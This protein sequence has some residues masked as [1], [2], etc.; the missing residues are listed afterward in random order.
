MLLLH[1]G[2]GRTR[3]SCV[4]MAKTSTKKTS[5]SAAIST[6]SFLPCS[7]TGPTVSMVMSAVRYRNKSTGAEFVNGEGGFTSKEM[8]KVID[9]SV[10][11]DP[12][13]DT[14][15]KFDAEIVG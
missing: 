5:G 1:A 9:V 4:S 15:K 12:V 13:V 3:W 10:L 14:L 6:C 8:A 7:L 11:G 2:D